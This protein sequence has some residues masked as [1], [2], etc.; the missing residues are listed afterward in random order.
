MDEGLSRRAARR[1]VRAAVRRFGRSGLEGASLD[2]VARDAEVSADSVKATYATKEQLLVEAQALTFAELHRRFVERANSG[3]RGLPAALEA[4]DS[5]WNSV[6]TLQDG[7]PF[8]VET[9]SLACRQGPLQARMG[10]F[11]VESTALLEDGI[12]RV[13]AEDLD[14]L[15]VPPDRMAVLIRILLEGLAVELA[16]AHTP[17]QLARVDQAYADMR[18]LFERFVLHAEAV[19]A[20]DPTGIETLPLPW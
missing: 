14:S 3:R 6:R 7:A 2:Q 12:R 8:V 20:L 16:Q 9:L 11:Y 5:L 17:G 18:A 15:A 10:R 19:P 1:V 4:L 13:F